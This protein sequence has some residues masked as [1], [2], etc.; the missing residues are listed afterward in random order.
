MIKKID[1]YAFMEWLWER[2]ASQATVSKTVDGIS[3][4]CWLIDH[5]CYS[6]KELWEKFKEEARPIGKVIIL[7]DEDSSFEQQK[8]YHSPNGFRFLPT[9]KEID[10]S[11]YPIHYFQPKGHKFSKFIAGVDPVKK[12]AEVIVTKIPDGNKS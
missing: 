10:K 8:L 11:S 5:V 9:Y 12:D 7:H 6:P 3:Y 1:L 2:D 4:H